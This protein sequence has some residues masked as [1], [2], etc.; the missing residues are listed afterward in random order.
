[1][2]NY[3]AQGGFVVTSITENAIPG[4]E[5]VQHS[6]TRGNGGRNKTLR[7][8]MESNN[9]NAIGTTAAMPYAVSPSPI[10]PFTMLQMQQ[11]KSPYLPNSSMSV[12]TIKTVTF[13]HAGN[14]TCAPS[15]ARPASITVHVL[16][17]ELKMRILSIYYYLISEISSPFRRKASG[18]ATC[19][20]K[21]SR[22][23][24]HFQ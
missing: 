22:W 23:R 19:K 2:V 12:L 10:S 17:G 9:D 1:M 15:N 16:R 24:V 5:N 7:S 14:Y 21:H 13:H 18:N 11:H 20:P 6:P 8:A 4:L 3:D